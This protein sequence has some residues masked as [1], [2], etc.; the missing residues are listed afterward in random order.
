MPEEVE[1][2]P[3]YDP[4]K[5]HEQEMMDSFNVNVVETFDNDPE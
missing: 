2:E 5:A 4:W 1:P 3:E